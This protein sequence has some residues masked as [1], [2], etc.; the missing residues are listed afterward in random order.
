MK[1]SVGIVL[2]PEVE[3]LAVVG[4]WQVFAALRRL[5]REACR[6]FTVSETGGEVLCTG[7]LPVRADHAFASAPRMDVLF[8]PGGPGHIQFERSAL[9]SYIRQAGAQADLV[10]SVCSGA[11]FLEEAGFLAGKRTTA[12]RASLEQLRAPG[13]A[14]VV[15]G[16][17]W[18]DAGAVITAAGGTA[19]IDVGLY[20]VRRLWGAEMARRVE[21]ELEYC[22]QLPDLTSGGR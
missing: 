8:V 10:V 9:I 12:D 17:R 22:P 4:P 6:L 13:T 11:L 15:T 18:V 16:V 2:F 20:L 21:Q 1:R 19:G 14:E 3:A 7:G 5:D